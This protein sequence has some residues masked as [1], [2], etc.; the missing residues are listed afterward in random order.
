[1]G[2]SNRFI[3]V[4]GVSMGLAMAACASTN[5]PLTRC[6]PQAIVDAGKLLAFHT[7]N[8]DRAELTPQVTRRGFIS[9]PGNPKHVLEVLEVFGAV[10]KA[11]YRVRL[12]YYRSR[13]S[14]VLIGQEIM[15][16]TTL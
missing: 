14:C 2:L 9:N 4:I 7:N 13:D 3:L 1:M 8:D 10:Y 12:N 6:H 15:E 11:Q 5:D 16:I